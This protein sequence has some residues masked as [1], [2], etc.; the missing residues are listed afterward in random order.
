MKLPNLQEAERLLQE[1]EKLNPGL[2][3]A[4]EICGPGC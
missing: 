3:Q 4:L 1:A 2:G